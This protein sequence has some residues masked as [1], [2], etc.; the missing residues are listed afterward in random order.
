M[1]TNS[2][3]TLRMA[4]R[5][6]L[7][8]SDDGNAIVVDSADY[9]WSTDRMY[10]AVRQWFTDHEDEMLTAGLAYRRGRT[11]RDVRGEIRAALFA[12]FPDSVIEHQEEQ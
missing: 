5:I 4:I 8:G 3:N 7:D 9:E 10:G 2:M 11:F 6:A 1:A 12:A